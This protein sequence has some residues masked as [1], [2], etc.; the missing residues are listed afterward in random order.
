MRVTSGMLIT[1]L[2]RNYKHNLSDMEVL[3]AQLSSGKRI[4]RPSDD[5]SGASKALKLRSDISSNEQYIKNVD[6]GISWLNITETALRDIG[7]TLQRARELTVRAA[8]E[9][10][11]PADRAAVADEI[12]QLQ[13]HLFQL[14]NSTYAGRY[15]FSGFRTDAPAFAEISPGA[16]TFQ[17]N[18]GEIAFE[19]SISNRI[20]VNVNGGEGGAEIAEVYDVLERLKNDLRDPAMLPAGGYIQEIDQR[21]NQ[22]LAQRST[23]G[24][25]INR[26]DMIRTR[27]MDSEVNY[28]EL[29]SKN[30]D[31]DIAR[32]IMHLKEA[33]VVYNASLAAGA[34]IIMPSLVDFLR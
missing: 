30:E 32:T 21:I 15:I 11:V 34:R 13:R 8:H 10:L 27:L 4:R 6:N 3:Q 28:T 2:M 24:A 22:V 7:D 19:V 14:G 12:E 31:V 18:N 26:F 1:N 17:G 16:I 23:V 20:A 25:K 29:L 33:E 5:P 9:T